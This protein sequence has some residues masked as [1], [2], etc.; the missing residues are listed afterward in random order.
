[1]QFG[2][3]CEA[4]VNIQQMVSAYDPQHMQ[5]WCWAASIEMIFGFYGYRVPQQAIVQATYGS[6]VNMPAV[7]G[8][9]ISRNLNRDWIDQSG[10]RF[11]VQIEGL[12][13]VDA[14]IMG[15]NNLQIVSALAGNRPLLMGNTSHAMVLFSA[16]YVPPA[17]IV[18]IGLADPWPGI[19]FRGPQSP[20]EMVPM[21]MG[22]A[23][24]YLCLPR[25]TQI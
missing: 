22:G 7:T 8:Y 1:M 25:I 5:Q 24:R 17:N 15:L 2:Q 12:F 13:D 10:R 21:H 9:V 14:Q 16:A 23:L 20:A 18:N 19:G 4:G 11:R 6:V 3:M